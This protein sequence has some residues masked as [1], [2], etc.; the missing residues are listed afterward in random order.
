MNW[1]SSGPF[2][3]FDLETTGFSAVRDRIIEIGAVRVELD[4]SVSR[5]QTL[6]NPGVPIP[7]R[8]TALTGI[9]DAMVA[10]APKFREAGFKFMD[11]ARRSRLVA[12][13]ARFDLR[14][15]RADQVRQISADLTA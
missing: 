4:G 1:L 11:F 12:H 5:F 6:V 7:P 3:V 10:D 13:N 2:T 15:L 8:L 9:D 14:F